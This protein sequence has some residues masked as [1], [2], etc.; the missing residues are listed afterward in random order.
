MHSKVES[1]E[2]FVVT[3][4]ERVAVF[5]V[6]SEFKFREKAGSQLSNK[7]NEHLT[8]H[9]SKFY[10]KGNTVNTINVLI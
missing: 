6:P 10:M 2:E 7:D 3:S 9:E 4:A 1:E 5:Q 8:S